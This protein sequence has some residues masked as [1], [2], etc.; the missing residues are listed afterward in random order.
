MELT[1]TKVGNTYIADYSASSHFNIHIEGG[2]RVA[3]FN[4]TSG[5]NWAIVT[6]FKTPVVDYDVAVNIPKT[7]R[8][9]CSENPSLCVI[10]NVQ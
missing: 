2:K 10:T 9:V 1:F 4:K 8:I 7:Y 3:L 6:E 5:E